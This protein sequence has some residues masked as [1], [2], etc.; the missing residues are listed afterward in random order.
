ME[1]VMQKSLRK[2]GYPFCVV[3]NFWKKIAFFKQGMSDEL[4]SYVDS[5]LSIPYYKNFKVYL[6]LRNY[7][8][9]LDQVISLYKL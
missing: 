5:L 7:N 4:L 9:Y 1:F 8:V 2:K 3:E 6:S